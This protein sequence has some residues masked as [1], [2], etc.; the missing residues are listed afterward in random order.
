MDWA[1]E[2]AEQAI[3]LEL[4]GYRNPAIDRLLDWVIVGGESG[5]KA[6]AFDVRWA[7]E[8]VQAC[9]DAGVAVFV[10][11]LGAE[12]RNWCAG[13]L[14]GEGDEDDPHGEECDAY[15]AHEGQCHGRC[16]WIEDRKKGADWDEWPPDIRVREFPTPSENGRVPAATP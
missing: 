12:P 3:A 2:F 10:K 9:R 16:F 4:D 11:Q 8:T 5:T 15:N 1:S 6:R 13:S 7:R 14:L